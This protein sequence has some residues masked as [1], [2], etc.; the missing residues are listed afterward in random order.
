MG[1]VTDARR[2]SPRTRLSPQ[3]RQAMILEAAVE[4]FAERG[5]AA[6]TRELAARLDISEPLIYRYFPTKEALVHQVYLT[7]IESRWD[8]EWTRALRDRSTSLRERLVGFY[9]RYL[10]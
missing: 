7:V 10:D 8:E 1:H 9:T 3:A 2:T 6:Q 5:F 4:F